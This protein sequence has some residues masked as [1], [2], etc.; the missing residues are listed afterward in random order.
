MGRSCDSVRIDRDF[1]SS[2]VYAAYQSTDYIYLSTVYICVSTS[3]RNAALQVSALGFMLD[4]VRP[5][6]SDRQSEISYGK[7][8]A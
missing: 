8:I 4:I 3:L 6:A 7:L 2:L 5:I 1:T